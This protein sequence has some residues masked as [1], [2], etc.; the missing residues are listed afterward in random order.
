MGYRNLTECVTDLER[1]GMLRK[2][3]LPIDPNL[4]MAEIQRRV[5]RAQG[6]ALLFTR[7]LN[8]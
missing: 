2:I 7:P 3:D 4:E 1:N 8:C 6:P 5:Y